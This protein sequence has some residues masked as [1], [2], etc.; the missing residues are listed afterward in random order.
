M[1]EKDEAIKQQ[2]MERLDSYLTRKEDRA[3]FGLLETKQK[4]WIIGIE[5]LKLSP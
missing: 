3:L 1:M 5:E 2:F 4:W